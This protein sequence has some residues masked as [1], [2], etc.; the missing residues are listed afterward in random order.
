M[1]MK[2]IYT[3]LLASV[4]ILMTGCTHNDGDIGPWFGTWQL[5][6]VM[7][8]DKPEEDYHH[9]IFWQFQNT[10]FCMRKVTEMHDAYPRWG[11]WQETDDNTTLQ[12]DFTHHDDTHPEGSTI[13]TPF[14]ETH[15]K[16]DGVTR[17]KIV[18]MSRSKLHLQHTADDG[19]TYSYYLKKWD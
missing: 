18:E 8:D 7:I 16:A 5:E 13:Y 14:P 10:V 1:T 3:L 2:S 11:T 9:D 17:L 6:N 12:L 19:I 4:F 15:I